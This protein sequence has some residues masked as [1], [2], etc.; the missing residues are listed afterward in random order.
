MLRMVAAIQDSSC[1]K[2]FREGKK[3]ASKLE[4]S[5]KAAAG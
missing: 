2:R 5:D 3:L 1:E 4:G